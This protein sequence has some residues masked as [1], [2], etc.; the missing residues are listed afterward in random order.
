VIYIFFS[1]IFFFFLLDLISLPYVGK[2]MFEFLPNELNF[3]LIEYLDLKSLKKLSIMNK[4]LYIILR[5]QI[6]IIALNK[7]K[8]FL[9][10]LEKP[11]QY[12]MIDEENELKLTTKDWMKMFY[13]YYPKLLLK[14]QLSLIICK[15]GYFFGSKRTEEMKIICELNS[16]LSTRYIIVKCI[17][18]M[19]KEEIV[20]IGW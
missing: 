2:L 3:I 17:S 15:I 1:F 5:K 16:H 9:T 6:Q 12:E 13:F 10:N 8:H 19:S 14:S 7:I 4:H 20:T 11:I 18:K